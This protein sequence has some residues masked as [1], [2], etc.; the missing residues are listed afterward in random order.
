MKVRKFLTYIVLS[1]LLVLV[2]STGVFAASG[3]SSDE[4]A[5]LD[6]FSGVVTKWAGVVVS[7]DT[8]KTNI[9]NQ[10]ISE[11]TNA[12]T[13]V[14]LDVAACD[15][16]AATIDAVDSLLASKGV[17]NGADLRAALPDVV[18]TVNATANKY[19]MTVSVV[20][21]ASAANDGYATVKITTET[22]EKTTAGG[23]KGAVNQ[24]GFTYTAT[25]IILSILALLFVACVVVTRKKNLIS[26]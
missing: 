4:Q 1:L 25:I 15:D 7:D 6:K 11:A 2:S 20:N 26:R 23:T 24:T 10:Y 14:D 17:K 19:G 9:Q 16:L 3:V 21:D 13:Q 5:L 12:L 22:G 8:K 18:A